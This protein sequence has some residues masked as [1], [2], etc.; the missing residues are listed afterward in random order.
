VTKRADDLRHEHGF[1]LIEVLVAIFLLLLG[2]LG[3]AKMADQANVAS[4]QSKARVGATNLAREL[5]EDTRSFKYADLQGRVPAGSG[6]TD[7]QDAYAG[8][9]VTDA[10]PSTPGFQVTRRGITYSVSIFTC[11]YD[12]SHDGVR[13]APAS[14][15]DVNAAGP[16]CLG[17]PAAGGTDAN[18][19]DARKLEVSV[20]WT[21]NGIAPS[22]KGVDQVSTDTG[23]SPGTG[24]ACV[25]QSQLIA[26][27]SGGLGPAIKT[28]TQE[29]PGGPIQ[30]GTTVVM[31]VTTASPAQS[32]TWTADNGASGTATQTSPD[33]L[34]WQITWTL[35]PNAPADGSHLIT[36]QAFLLNAGGVPKEASVT[37]N[38]FIPA[39]PAGGTGGID[40]RL[41]EA[42]AISWNPNS[43]QDI[44]G[45]TVYRVGNSSDPTQPPNLTT[46]PTDQAVCSTTSVTST[47]CFDAPANLHSLA[48]NSACIDPIAKAAGD[49]CINYYVVAFDSKW[50]SSNPT[51]YDGTVCQGLA[52][53]GVNV[54]APPVSASLSTPPITGSSQWP[55][56]R[57]GCPS[58]Y[59]SIDYTTLVGNHQPNPPT[60]PTCTTDS[61][62]P[63]IGWTSATPS[64]DQDGDDIVAY[65]IYRDPPGGGTPQYNDPATTIG[66]S[67]GPTSTY[68]DSADTGGTGHD[69]WVTAVDARFQES[70]PL[71]IQWT[72]ASC[73]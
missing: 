49:E 46:S 22:C 39:V 7:L 67:S 59:I 14:G 71:H 26:N 44:F 72:A 3:V 13:A 51:S 9:G 58:A 18:P 25:T 64:P 62:Q 55:T 53:S 21:T 61:G 34:Q 16:Y 32:V 8:V 63:V 30:S 73:P 33:G 60:S 38:R 20:K 47:L 42:V 1:T 43:D 65:R 50:T 70:S 31:D 52:W 28:F 15:P 57:A 17:S 48:A 5:L 11:V 68:R 56:A 2:V 23:P 45:Y 35:G 36:A 69:Y 41:S 54:P 29:A 10:K 40:T 37:L 24:V 4:N 19:D 27:P 6:A 12:D 66:Y